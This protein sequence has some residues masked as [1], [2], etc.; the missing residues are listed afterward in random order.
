V[1]KANVSKNRRSKA[2]RQSKP[3]REL[4]SLNGIIGMSGFEFE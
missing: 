1:A 3:R 4:Q 2:G